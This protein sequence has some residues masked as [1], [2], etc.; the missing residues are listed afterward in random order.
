MAGVEN[1]GEARLLAE[2]V[3]VSV[4]GPIS[5]LGLKVAPQKTEAV[6]FHDGSRRA[7][8]KSWVLMDGVPVHVGLTIKYL[9]LTLDGRW[10]FEL[11]FRYLAPRV[12]KTSLALANL[13][14]T[15]GG[16]GWR[17]RLLYVGVVLSIALY[18]VPIWAPQLLSSR[19]SKCLLRQ[20]MRW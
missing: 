12:R 5:S 8:L 1:W 2:A 9:G 13:M 3:L 17:A 10:D 7:P 19:R 14:K 4:V 16:P 18:G 20:A 15:Q 11:H 6:F